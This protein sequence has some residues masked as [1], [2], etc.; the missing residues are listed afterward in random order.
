MIA[1]YVTASGALIL[2]VIVSSIKI[3][4]PLEESL[5]H[6]I[7]FWTCPLEIEDC[8]SFVPIY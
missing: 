7:Y 6:T 5:D 3:K 4:F 2:P 8:L 1:E